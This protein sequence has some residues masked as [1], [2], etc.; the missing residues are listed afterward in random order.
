MLLLK[1]NISDTAKLSYLISMMLERWVGCVPV[2]VS[3]SPVSSSFFMRTF[4]TQSFKQEE[5]DQTLL[6]GLNHNTLSI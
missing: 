3:V 6:L 4:S 2:T 1:E 5:S